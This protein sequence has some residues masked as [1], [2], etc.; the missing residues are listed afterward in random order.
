MTGTCVDR[1]GQQRGCK[2]AKPQQR[3]CLP[4]RLTL[5]IRSEFLRVAKEVFILA[6]IITTFTEGVESA[7]WGGVRRTD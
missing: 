1:P 2:S 5:K 4:F 3:G 7:L 6:V